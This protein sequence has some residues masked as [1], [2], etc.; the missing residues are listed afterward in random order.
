MGCFLFVL[1]C[2]CGVGLCVNSPRQKDSKHACQPEKKRRR[3]RKRVSFN[4]QWQ[5]QRQQPRQ[6][7]LCRLHNFSCGR[8]RDAEHLRRRISP[9]TNITTCNNTSNNTC[10]S[11]A[12]MSLVLQPR[13]TPRVRRG[14]VAL[15]VLAVSLGV[16]AVSH[17]LQA[18]ALSASADSSSLPRL[19]QRRDVPSAPPR[20]P[21]TTPTPGGAFAVSWEAP[22]PGTTNGAITGYVIRIR[23]T[24][25]QPPTWAYGNA[26]LDATDVEVSSSTF[27]YT[28]ADELS[29]PFSGYDVGVA[30]K[31]AEGFGPFAMLSVDPPNSIP[32]GQPRSVS[33]SL[34]PVDP[35]TYPPDADEVIVQWTVPAGIWF[36]NAPAI[37]FDLVATPVPGSTTD[38]VVTVRFPKQWQ[39]GDSPDEQL[40]ASI[41]GL[42]P[43]TE[44]VVLVYTIGLDGDRSTASFMTTEKTRPH[45]PTVAPAG[46][47]VD[48]TS[49]TTF[50]L[51]W[52]AMSAS[53]PGSNG[54]I[55]GYRIYHV[56]TADRGCTNM[57]CAPPTPCQEDPRCEFGVCTYTNK[58]NFTSCDDGNA[59]TVSDHCEAG[60][61]IGTL[62]NQH[63]DQQPVHRH[64]Y[65]NTRSHG[66]GYMP[67]LG[68]F[69]Y[70]SWSGSSVYRYAED[71]TYKTNF[72]TS[73]SQIMQLWGEPDSLYYYTANWGYNYCRK[74]GPFPSTSV[75]WTYTPSPATTVGGI[76]TDSNY[77]YCIQNGRST[78]HVLN[79]ETG[80]LVRTFDLT[81][82]SIG[83]L[84][85]GFAVVNDKIYYGTGQYFYRHNLE[86]GTFDGFRFQTI[87]T[88]SNMA[89][90]GQDLCISPNSDNV[91]CYQV[92]S[93]NI[94]K[95][96]DGAHLLDTVNA[97][98]SL[99][100]NT[101]S[102]AGGFAPMHREYWYPYWSGS[103]I[104][105]YT[106]KGY[107]IGAF[108]AVN[109]VG[110]IRQLWGS[111][112]SPH[113]YLAASNYIYKA[114]WPQNQLVW[115]YNLGTTAGGVTTHGDSVYAMRA[116]TNLVYVLRATDGELQRTFNLDSSSGDNFSN[117]FG[118][119]VAV[120]G[121]LFRGGRDNARFYRSVGGSGGHDLRFYSNCERVSTNP[122]SYR[123]D[124][125]G[126]SNSWATGSSSIYVD[127]MEVFYLT[128]D[129][130]DPC[131]GIVCPTNPC[132][133]TNVCQLGVCVSTTIPDGTPCDD[134]DATTAFDACVAGQC[135]GAARYSNTSS[136]TLDDLHP[137]R[138]YA[139]QV[140][141][142]TSIGGG[143]L[144][145]AVHGTTLE[146]PPSSGPVDVAGTALSDSKIK[147]TW[148]APANPTH[149]GRLLGYEVY[150]ASAGGPAAFVTSLN[151]YTFTVTGLLPYTEYTFYL[152][153]FNGAGASPPSES[154]TVRTQEAPPGPP[155]NVQADEELSDNGEVITVS[156]QPPYEPNGIVIKY[157]IYYQ[158]LG[159]TWQSV[160]TSSGSVRSVEIDGLD[161]IST[162]VVQVSAWTAAGEG[163]RSNTIAPTTGQ[164]IPRTP[165]DNVDANAL[166]KTAIKVTYDLPPSDEGEVVEYSIYYTPE[167][168]PSS[169]E[170]ISCHAR[171]T[172]HDVGECIHDPFYGPMCTAPAKRDGTECDDGDDSTGFDTCV[173]GQCRSVPRPQ[174][175]SPVTSTFS[176]TWSTRS[177]GMAYNPRRNEWWFPEY[178]SSS[179]GTVVYRYSADDLTTLVGRF[180]I[181]QR[182]YLMQIWVHVDETYLLNTYTDNYVYRYGPFPLVTQLW[183]YNFGTTVGGVS[184]HDGVVY[185]MQSGSYN[186][187]VLD[188]ETGQLQRSFSLSGSPQGFSNIYGTFAVVSNKIFVGDYND[189]DMYRFDLQT[190]QYDN[191][192]WTASYQTQKLGFDGQHLC[193]ASGDPVEC[194]RIVDENVYGDRT[195]ISANAP[196]QAIMGSEILTKDMNLA[197][198]KEVSPNSDSSFKLC[199]RASDHGFSGSTFHA[200]CDNKGQ[201]VVVVRST[202]GSPQGPRVF[203]AFAPNSWRS[204]TSTYL[205]A[206]DAFLFRFVNNGQFERTDLLN[207]PEYAQYTRPGY[208]PEFGNSD[209]RMSTDCR[210]GYTSTNAYTVHQSSSTYNNE[211]LTGSYN[212][213]QVDDVEV[214]YR[215]DESADPCFDVT[216]DPPM[217]QCKLPGRC[218]SG[219]CVYDVAPN[220]TPCNDGD[221]ATVFDTCQDTV[222]VGRHPVITEDNQHTFTGLNP[223]TTYAFRVAARTVRGQGPAS[224]AVRARTL[225]G[226]PTGPPQDVVARAAATTVLHITWKQPLFGER[227]GTISSY[228]LWVQRLNSMRQPA[229]TPWTIVTGNDLT[230]YNLTDLDAYTYYQ[231]KVAASTIDGLGPYSDA[232]IARTAEGTPPVAPTNVQVDSTT[233]ETVTLSW[234]P[235]SPL[236]ADG[237]LIGYTISVRQGPRSDCTRHPASID[238][239]YIDTPRVETYTVLELEDTAVYPYEFQV[240]ART[241]AGEGV[242]SASALHMTSGGSQVC[243][244]PSTWTSDVT[245]TS[246][247]VW[248]KPPPTVE[249]NGNTIATINVTVTAIEDSNR[250]PITGATPAW[251]VFSAADGFNASQALSGLDPYTVYSVE[252]VVIT[253]TGVSSPTSAPYTFR[254][255]EATPG[256]VGSLIA[257]EVGDVVKVLWTPPSPANGALQYRIT[258]TPAVDGTSEFTTSYANFSLDVLSGTTYTVRVV[259]LTGAGDGPA[260]QTTVE[261]VPANVAA[262]VITLQSA[263]ETELRLKATWTSPLTAFHLQYKAEGDDD[264]SDVMDYAVSTNA[265][266]HT[267]TLSGLE[268]STS[269]TVRVQ[270]DT[271]DGLGLTAQY[272]HATAVV[273][274][275]AP[276][277]VV[278]PTV[279]TN[280]RSHTRAYTHS[281]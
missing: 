227:H 244:G 240:A 172:C 233:T 6:Q 13:P 31:N 237:I 183:A 58:P 8:I 79:K 88:I 53:T 171:D 168:L 73:S 255:A 84:N 113:Y 203:G 63:I 261:T 107:Y 185:A 169:C 25:P 211:W 259:A 228:K 32:S 77:A 14:C 149:N 184:L 162:Y 108:N 192:H 144:S 148:N 164:G 127:E 249:L 102:Y 207:Y 158:K 97:Y 92:I 38:E 74:I 245:S 2:V 201:T 112:D 173:M 83:S 199:F 142:Y 197:I 231:V 137:G 71:G 193:I 93:H 125:G 131:D 116:T 159:G 232:S 252:A 279:L 30:V 138:T 258:F 151:Y 225:S 250:R 209:F 160:T 20:N 205:R 202:E 39:D 78:V 130:Y 51:S 194:W 118:G 26:S 4:L 243:S 80:S 161:P 21:T 256:A 215:V 103:T 55:V 281:L 224:D 3:P 59:H 196:A 36:R 72:G 246:A 166:S 191:V 273:P 275:S 82:G 49:A 43:N 251:L 81:G 68:E 37:G 165:P 94:W 216:C 140:Q 119:L 17:P 114:T 76:A 106:W 128:E 111:P 174:P 110:S 120:K 143:P 236:E 239:V 86:D 139:V 89:F 230:N 22:D 7:C 271:D 188:W 234:D 154:I 87:Q 241:A 200:R 272:E 186:I 267:F 210:S 222:C 129:A 121:R 150:I 132:T 27:S 100:M 15:L 190:Y 123:I 12:P 260:R 95:P 104:Y 221:D 122:N 65:M 218:V 223:Y 208:C 153:T 23:P 167:P 187:R 35:M 217:G 152:T 60:A 163:E 99:S 277:T 5:Q 204:D 264:F 101:R 269:Y 19:R 195:V 54:D 265:R 145:D 52:D 242:Y 124:T 219:E 1:V 67:R 155:S 135:V 176:G 179:T 11:Q 96:D 189:N 178:T 181:Q 263:A 48:D 62:V 29:F 115:S 16:L 156:W 238:V 18:K 45:L 257:Q 42:T 212:S 44:Y 105:R 198:S 147:L 24:A 85:G 247:N 266:Q 274:P 98:T 248:V 253:T 75:R 213:W 133:P 254:T 268:H 50:N 64:I 146:A 69:W 126:Y 57:A 170:E 157:T 280:A 276:Q 235:I 47:S 61:C 141:A 177:Y 175:V 262:P 91:Y 214:F 28:L 33:T 70:P 109:G 41:T 182:R 270:A 34:P 229:G 90:T 117:M 206:D 134:G 56:P 10:L 136:Y 180:R 40:T 66:G 226:T 278:V 9:C 46:L 220:G